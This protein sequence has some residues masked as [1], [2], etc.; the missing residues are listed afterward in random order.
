MNYF[1][2]AMK[3]SEI[4]RVKEVIDNLIDE[5]YWEGLEDGEV[6]VAGTPQHEIDVEILKNLL[7]TQRQEIREAVESVE[8]MIEARDND[9]HRYQIP[10]SKKSEWEEFLD[11]PE[12]DERS[13]D[14]P[15]WA[16][17]IDGMPLTSVKHQ[18]LSLPELKD[19]PV[20]TE[21]E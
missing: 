15:K 5:S 12:D 3:Q 16:D 6:G 19:N 14:V 17:R 18:I 9:S 13:W 4:E 2:R 10:K 7:K 20:N 8:E 21:E 11:I 1:G